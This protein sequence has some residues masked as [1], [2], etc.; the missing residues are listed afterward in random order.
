MLNFLTGRYF[1]TCIFYVPSVLHP[2]VSKLYL[3]YTGDVRQSIFRHIY[4]L[5][6]L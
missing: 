4:A 1:A 6:M 3:N 2:V 5:N